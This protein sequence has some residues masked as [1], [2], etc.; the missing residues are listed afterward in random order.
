MVGPILQDLLTSKRKMDIKE[1]STTTIEAQVHSDPVQKKKVTFQTISEDPSTGNR[2]TTNPP[3]RLPEPPLQ[4]LIQA[5]VN[6]I[7]QL[8]QFKARSFTMTEISTV[9]DHP[10]LMKQEIGRAHV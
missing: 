6:K 10:F 1:V 5:R 8:L 9:N 3:E 2:L 4:T 7:I